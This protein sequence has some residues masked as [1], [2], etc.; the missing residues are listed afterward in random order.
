MHRSRPASQ[1]QDGRCKGAR[2]PA[3]RGCGRSRDR[4]CCCVCGMAHDLAWPVSGRVLCLHCRA[5]HG[6][7]AT[8]PAL[9]ASATARDVRRADQDALRRARYA[10]RRGRNP[11]EAPTGGETRR[12]SLRQD[13]FC[14]YRQYACPERAELYCPCRKDHRSCRSIR[15]WQDDR[16][17]SLAGS[18]APIERRDLYRQ[19]VH[20][21]CLPLIS[22]Q[23]D[24]SREP[25]R[26]H[27]RGDGS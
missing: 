22:A 19:P 9:T 3:S 21:G 26:V 2:E 8:P 7:R 25:G 14:L 15:Q 24:G 18:L 27:V 17:Q 11:D 4:R 13:L 12:S 23:A 1:Q 5:A 20:C 16:I 10:R 6:G